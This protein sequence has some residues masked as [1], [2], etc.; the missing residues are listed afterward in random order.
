VQLTG[1]TIVITGAE[2]GIGKA[3]A[4]ACVQAGARVIL[5]GINGPLLDA[6]VAELRGTGGPQ[7]A[8]GVRTDIRDESQVNALFER[9]LQACGSIDGA[10][11]NAGVIGSKVQ[12][13]EATREVW[14]EVMA[15]NLTGTYLTV[16]AAARI[17]VAQGRGGSIIATGSSSALR[18]VPGLMAYAASKGAVHTMMQALAVELGP[19]R[20]R[21]NTLVPGT[22]ATDATRAIPGDYL[23][24]AA[25]ALP[26][27]EVVQPEELGR[28]VAFAFSDALPHLTGS[29][30]KVDAGRTIA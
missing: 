24:E 16:L 11:A 4:I 17:L 30:L 22:T 15:V 25:R 18:T 12:A 28:Y 26:M 7:A 9:A 8:L 3:A 13:V 20:I 23:A 19:H 27:R 10:F 29:L 1:K 5:G 21:V 2:S 6:C 14:D